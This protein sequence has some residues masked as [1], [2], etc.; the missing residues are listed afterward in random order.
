[1]HFNKNK[2][3]KI[4]T[5]IIFNNNLIFDDKVFVSS[6]PQGT[7]DLFLH[8]VQ[9]VFRKNVK[10]VD[11]DLLFDVTNQHLLSV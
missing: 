5:I 10:N 6:N 7:H 1:M 2:S 4:I 11:Q 9:N 8:L 3:F